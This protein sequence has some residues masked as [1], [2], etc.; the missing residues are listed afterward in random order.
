[1]DKSSICIPKVNRP[2][3][4]ISTMVASAGYSATMKKA[5]FSCSILVQS[6]KSGFTRSLNQCPSKGK[7]I[8]HL[9]LNYKEIKYRQKRHFYYNKTALFFYKR[10]EQFKKGGV[11]F[12]LFLAF[13]HR[14][15]CRSS[16]SLYSYFKLLLANTYKRGPKA[17]QKDCRHINHYSHLTVNRSTGWSPVI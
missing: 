2:K 11:T 1:M 5:D 17:L 16:A 13:S 15:H 7:L 10:I 6:L 12:L 9:K 3:C 4:L 14:F 8:K